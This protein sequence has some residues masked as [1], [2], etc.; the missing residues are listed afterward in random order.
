[1]M[2]PETPDAKTT[3]DIKDAPFVRGMMKMTANMYRLGWDERNGGNISLL[4]DEEDVAPYL[5]DA[6]VLRR[7]PLGFTVKELAGRYFLVTGTGGY[8]KNI[9]DDPETNLGLFRIAEDGETADLLW[10]YKGGGTFTSELPAHLMCHRARLR[11][12]PENR[13]IMHSH[14]THT[15]AMN[16]VH[17]LDERSFTHTLWQMSTECIVVFPEGI[18]ILPWMVCGTNEIGEAT[19]AKMKDYRL[20]IWAM[21]G[22][23]GSGRT[24]DDAFG[25]LETVEK[26]AEIYMLTAHLPRVNTIQDDELRDLAA[27]FG[28]DYREDFLEGE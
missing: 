16:Y 1:M 12:D 23:Y 9:T 22:I 14:P 11:E 2:T 13:V 25:L 28:V 15:L 26:A 20:V 7:L 17:A 4:L 8:F 24:L 19:A 21:H 6:A 10:G 3:S 18:G 5:G 27:F